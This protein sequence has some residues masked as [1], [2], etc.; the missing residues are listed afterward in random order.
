MA[1]TSKK[2][3]N[4]ES[5][6]GRPYKGVLGGYPPELVDQIK[7]LRKANEGWGAISILVELEEEY[8]YS[9]SDLPSQASVN[10]YLKQEGFIKPYEPKGILP[11]NPC[12]KPRAVHELWEVDA[13]GATKVSGIGYQ[14]M[15]N[16]KD[17]QSK[18][19]CMAF[20]VAVKNQSSQPATVHYKWAFRLA[21]TESG[22]PQ[23]I[24]VDKD[25]VFIE[26]TSKSPYPGR[27]HLWLL[28]LD[29][30]L[31][32]INVPPPAKQA[33]VER[34]HQTIEKQVIQGKHYD[35]WQQFFKNTTKRRKRLNEKFPNRMLDKKA[36][37]QVY[38][39]AA[40]STRPYSVK[41]EY[42]LLNLNRIYTFLS[43]AKWYRKT[44]SGKMVSLGAQRYYLKNAVPKSQVQI[45]FC[46]QTRLLIFRDVKE[47]ELAQL[48]VKGL[49]KKD[50]MGTDSKKLIAMNKKLHKVRDFPLTT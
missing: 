14:A 11:V 15:I 48:P 25:S 4:A 33:M 28:A 49:S 38:P 13:Q 45:T 47:Q 44:S 34:S 32:F 41:Q 22:L 42:K 23:I 2:R 1:A 10:R 30:E 24:Q 31:C 40:H 16:M 27:L 12:K 5:E 9:K 20:P 18:K 3:G 39:E 46:K 26:N 29:V 35:D 7:S 21:F 43:K 6:M 36:P 8:S 50:L 17:G 37:L 19:H